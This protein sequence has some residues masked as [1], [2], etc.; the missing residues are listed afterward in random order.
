MRDADS[1]YVVCVSAGGGRVALKSLP[2]LSLRFH[3]VKSAVPASALRAAPCSTFGV[4]SSPKPILENFYS[5]PPQLMCPFS[6]L[7]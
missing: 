1:D 7:I 6:P 2:L 3:E 4:S 5:S